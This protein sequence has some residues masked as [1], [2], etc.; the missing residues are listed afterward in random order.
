MLYYSSRYM[1]ESQSL[2]L[3]MWI[4]WNLMWPHI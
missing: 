2:I 4:W 1:K 3:K